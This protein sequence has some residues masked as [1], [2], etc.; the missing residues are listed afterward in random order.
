MIQ[1]EYRENIDDCKACEHSFYTNG[2]LCCDLPKCKNKY[3]ISQ[4]IG[5]LLK[6]F[7]GFLIT[8]ALCGILF[9][10]IEIMLKIWHLKISFLLIGM[11]LF[12][13]MY[14]IYWLIEWLRFRK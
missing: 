7:C 1:V 5:S 10:G 11:G 4:L 12:I 8:L 6:I 3:K 13:P 9:M 2:D 14:C